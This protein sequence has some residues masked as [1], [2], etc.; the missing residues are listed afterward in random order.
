MDT[1]LGTRELTIGDT[2]LDFSTPWPRISMRDL[3]LRDS[4]IDYATLPDADA[5]RAAIKAEG[6]QL[7][8]QGIE[9]MSRGNLIDQLY[10]KVSRPA[11]VNPTFVTDHP[12]IGA[13]QTYH[14]FGGMILRGP[15]DE[16]VGFNRADLPVFE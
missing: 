15:G 11:L 3:I 14:N 5:V 6:I 10:K 16:S 13:F 12:N 7:E 9:T 8:A 1:L 2:T 4:G